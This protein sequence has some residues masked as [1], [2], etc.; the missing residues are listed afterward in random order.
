[1]PPRERTVVA[2]CCKKPSPPHPRSRRRRLSL[3]K[4][5]KVAYGSSPNTSIP[6]NQFPLTNQCLMKSHRASSTSTLFSRPPVIAGCPISF[7]SDI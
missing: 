7:P 1:M 5:P 2:C 4:Q 6:S 3:A